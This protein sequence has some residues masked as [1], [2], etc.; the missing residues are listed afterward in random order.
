[1][2]GGGGGAGSAGGNTPGPGPAGPGGNGQAS[3]ITGSSVTYAGGG[4]F[5][6]LMLEVEILE[7]VELA[8]GG[9]G[10]S[11]NQTNATGTYSTGGGGGGHTTGTS[12]KNGGSGIVVVRYQIDSS[13]SDV[14][15][16]LV[17]PSVTMAIKQFMLSQVL[18]TLLLQQHLMKL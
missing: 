1:M 3:S 6:V 8:G 4:W 7:V 13:Q 9:S 11:P 2:G 12:G 14:Q 15:K 5:E 10:G 16:H 17:V 18:E